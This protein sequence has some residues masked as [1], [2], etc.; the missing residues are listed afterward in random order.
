MR[1]VF[2]SHSFSPKDRPLDNVG[3]M[4]RVAMD[5]DAALEDIAASPSPGDI[6]GFTYK[7]IVLEARWKW[8]HVLAVPFL[9]KTYFQLLLHIRRREVDVIL[10]SSMVTAA[11]AV[12]LRGSLHANGVRAAAIVHG[13][14]VTKPVRAYQAF[15]P[16]VFCALDLVLPVS[17]ATGE[18]CIARGLP[19]SKLG[20]V[21]NG[22]KL[23]RFSA[24][25]WPAGERTAHPFRSELPINAFLLVSVGRQVKRKG[26]AWFINEVMPRLPENVHYW[27]GGDGPE[28][29]LIREAIDSNGLQHRVKLLGRLGDSQLAQLYQSADI[30]VMPNIEVPGDMEG[31]GVVM[32]EAGLNGLPT[33]AARLEGIREVIT[34]GENGH[35]VTTEN[36]TEYISLIVALE[37]DRI[38][39]A[40][41]SVSSARHVSLTFAWETVARNYLN[42]LSRKSP[43]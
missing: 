5:L 31:F 11:L 34:E 40:E 33:V 37:A 43:A 27:L 28:S 30:F 6:D 2:V 36:V 18:A 10:F 20:V 7:K 17:A 39:L 22:V 23:D 32:L 25:K 12:L 24:Y 3:G 35:F 15:V 8:V 42:T 16:R 14:D 29:Q 41:L 1:L 9:I 19:P 4:Q 38:R 21:H 13:Q 26:F